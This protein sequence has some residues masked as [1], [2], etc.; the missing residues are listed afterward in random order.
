[1]ITG[2]GRPSLRPGVITGYDLLSRQDNRV[3]IDVQ[4]RLVLSYEFVTSKDKR[5]EPSNTSTEVAEQFG[6]S[7]RP[8]W[9]VHISAA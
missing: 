3:G 7:L 6:Y 5:K 8:T 2:A 9:Y 1:M 4:L